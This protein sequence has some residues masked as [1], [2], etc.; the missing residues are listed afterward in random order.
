M[1]EYPYSTIRKV[2]ERMKRVYEGTL[3]EA[4]R[5]ELGRKI[6]TLRL[7]YRIAQRTIAERIKSY[8][9]DISAAEHGRI[10][11]RDY[12]DRILNAINDIAIERAQMES[13]RSI[14]SLRQQMALGA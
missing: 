6:T 8:Q 2:D 4:E 7:E 3:R 9:P 12:Y 1:V 5:I 14:A 13:A 11:R 10:K